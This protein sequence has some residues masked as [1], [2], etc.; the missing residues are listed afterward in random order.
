MT[1]RRV[2]FGGVLALLAWLYFP[3]LRDDPLLSRD[4]LTLL[5]PLRGVHSV[6]DY[7]ALLGTPALMDLQPLRDASYL[8]DLW[9]GARL[10]HST[11]H[12]TSFVLF[13]LL[14]LAAWRLFEALA[15]G[16]PAFTAVVVM[17]LHPVWGTG[18]AW[19]AARK[20]LLACLLLTL[21]TE[22]LLQFVARG[23]AR[24]AALAV[25]CFCCSLLAHPI[26]LGWPLFALVLLRR[27]HWLVLSG[28]V[29]SLTMMAANVWYYTGPYAANGGVEKYAPGFHPGVS[30]LALGRAFFNLTA[31]V[32]LATSYT[33]GAVWNLVG[34]GALVL[35]C[36]LLLRDGAW[37]RTGPWLLY[38]AL[39]L[40]VV[41]VRMTNVF[42]ADTYLFSPGVGVLAAVLVAQ[43]A[44]GLRGRRAVFSVAVAAAPLLVFESAALA[45]SY[46]SEAA[47]WARAWEVEESPDALAHH[48]AYVLDAGR[49]EEA[50]VLALRLAEW[51]PARRNL[52]WLLGRAIVT[53]SRLGPEEKAALFEAHPVDDAWFHYFHAQVA[54]QQGDVP[55]ARA[56]LRLALR[57]P[58]RFGQERALVERQARELCQRAGETDCR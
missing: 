32:A 12:L 8:L 30:L 5:A 36:A 27:P 10:G 23:R 44:W 46:T 4:D 52:G 35:T 15:P 50:L 9:L 31:P 48:A 40:G 20:H 45:H 49:E 24:D 28:A 43:Q 16:W 17:A 2:M 57:T 53:Q 29:A 6:G 34:L 19:V 55:R 13:G 38:A 51:D 1:A 22:R 18:L 3:L 25:G 26:G 39:P 33:P 56:L 11:F 21:A 47:L 41:L 14:L 7:A 42:L 37:R 58:E 54:L